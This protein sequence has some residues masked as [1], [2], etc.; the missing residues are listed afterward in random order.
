MK[1]ARQA[2]T[3]SSCFYSQH[4]PTEGFTEQSRT[5]DS[6]LAIVKTLK[7]VDEGFEISLALKFWPLGLSL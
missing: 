1:T 2:R 3:D 4:E 6:H 5:P 7:W